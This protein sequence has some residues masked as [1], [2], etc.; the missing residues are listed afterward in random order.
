MK[1][2]VLL[3]APFLISEY[4]CGAIRLHCHQVLLGVDSLAHAPPSGAISLS[5]VVMMRYSSVSLEYPEIQDFVRSV[6]NVEWVQPVMPFHQII[7]QYGYP[8]ALPV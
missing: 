6:P 7:E 1:W 2:R 3:D 4:C 8:A 5:R